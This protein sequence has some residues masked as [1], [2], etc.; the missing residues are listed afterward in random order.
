[1]V[2]V[3][4]GDVSSDSESGADKKDRP[5]EIEAAREEK[6]KTRR[7]ITPRIVLPVVGFT[8]LAQVLT[9]MVALRFVSTRVSVPAYEPFGSSIQGSVGNSLLLIVTVFVV[10]FTMVWLVRIKRAS[11]IRRFLT[12]FVSFTAFSLTLLL[13]DVLIRGLV[14]SEYLTPISAGLGFAAAMV[15]GYSSVNPDVRRLGVLASLILAVEVAAYLSIFIRPPTLLIMPV[16]FAVYDI[17][18]VF[19]GPL[20]TLIASSDRLVLGPLVAKLGELEVGLGDIA[21]YSLLPASGYILGGWGGALLIVAATNVG[22]VVTLQMLRRRRSFP[23]LPIP[24]LLGTG[25]LLL[26]TL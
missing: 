1:V 23:G 17:Y 24:V 20:K 8:L 13:G 4:E 15:V 2:I 10:T 12:V 21:F 25:L 6:T 7:R 22:L 9:I 5:V 18:A 16:V 26:M 19:L 14:D 11:L 3:I